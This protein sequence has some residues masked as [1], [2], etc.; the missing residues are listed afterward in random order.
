M[1]I[2][3]R[4]GRKKR[5][6]PARPARRPLPRRRPKW[7]W[8]PCSAPEGQMIRGGSHRGN[9]NQPEGCCSDDTAGIRSIDQYQAQRTASKAL[10]KAVS[11]HLEGKHESAARTLAK[12]IEGGERD[13]A[14][15]AALGH[16][17]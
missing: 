15:Y 14:L 5:L 12:A 11:L 6:S 17:Q 16:I 8:L 4:W 7:L 13:P 9:C 2:P 1:R 3:P 10:S